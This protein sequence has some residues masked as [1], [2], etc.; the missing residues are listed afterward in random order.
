MDYGKIFAQNMREARKAVGMSQESL[1]GKCGITRNNIGTIERGEQS[2]RL[3]TMTAI[4]NALEV[5]LP[6]L[7]TMK[8]L[9][10]SASS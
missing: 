8:D 3:E 1:A 10:K 9:Q 6:E 2:P 4:A 5:T 7:L